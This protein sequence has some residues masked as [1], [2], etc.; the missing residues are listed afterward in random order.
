MKNSETNQKYL[1]IKRIN[2]YGLCFQEINGKGYI[3]KREDLNNRQYL[4]NLMKKNKIEIEMRMNFIK[5]YKEDLER[6]NNGEILTYTDF[7][8]QAPYSEKII[9]AKKIKE[10]ISFQFGNL[11][12]AQNREACFKNRIEILGGFKFSEDNVKIG[13]TVEIERYIYFANN[14]RHTDIIKITNKDIDNITGKSILH[15]YSDY[16]YKIPYALINKIIEE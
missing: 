6:I 16:S 15:N 7:S 9:T 11:K 1:I 2:E 14:E 12:I 4:L 13:D 10:K 5:S 3:I 8:T